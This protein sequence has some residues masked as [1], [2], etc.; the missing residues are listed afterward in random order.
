MAHRAVA[1][2]AIVPL[3]AGFARLREK[4]QAIDIIQAGRYRQHQGR[5]ANQADGGEI[6]G[7]VEWCLGVEQ[8]G[9]RQVA[10]DHHADGVV[11]AGLG[12]QVGGNVAARTGVVFNNDA[13]AQRP[14]QR[15]GKGARHQI[16]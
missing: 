13:L 6:F 8:S 1:G 11:V 10:I 7:R 5:R 9:N 2:R 4:V 15:L 3:R 16:R 14:G 12:H